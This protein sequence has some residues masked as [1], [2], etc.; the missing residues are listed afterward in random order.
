M[1][2]ITLT[3][4]HKPNVDMAINDLQAMNLLTNNN[5]KQTY[6]GLGVRPVQLWEFV[7]PKEHLEFMLATM[8]Y[9]D[10]N[11]PMVEDK[12]KWIRR[13]LKLKKIP[14]LDYST[15]KRQLIRKEH[16]AFHHIGIKEDLF[17]NGTE[18]L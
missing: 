1:H 6:T 10:E 7:F 14:K 18:L 17:N 15:L 9:R 8:H 12:F 4:G 2:L 3:R 16:V 11:E 13:A 5:G